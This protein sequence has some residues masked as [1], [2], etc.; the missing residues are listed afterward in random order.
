MPQTGAN[1]SELLRTFRVA[2]EEGT[3]AF[4]GGDVEAA[5][6]T[7]PE[8]FEIHTPAIAPD[9]GVL[10]GADEIKRFL[11]EM[12][13]VFPDWRIE[14]QELIDAGENTILTHDRM[15]GTGQSSGVSVDLDVFRIWEFREA[16]PVRMRE[17]TDRAEALEAA[18]IT[19]PDQSP[20]D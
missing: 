2:Y 16:V 6:A 17:Y 19:S 12:R 15:S 11:S 1:E 4:N 7:A 20:E 3:R 13:E 18:G 8:D 14:P 5:F 9:A 10:R